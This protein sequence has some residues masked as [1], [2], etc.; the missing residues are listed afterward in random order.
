MS[1]RSEKASK[2]FTSRDQ[3]VIDDL[4]AE[5]DEAKRRLRAI[6]NYEPNEIAY[7]KFAYD[8]MVKG[9][10]DVAHGYLGTTESKGDADET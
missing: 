4:R 3:R 5:L 2:F 9:F 1:E 8:R 6:I 7:D 10:R